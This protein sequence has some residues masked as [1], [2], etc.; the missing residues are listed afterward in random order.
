MKTTGKK[1]KGDR[2]LHNGSRASDIFFLHVLFCLYSLFSVCSKLG[3]QADSFSLPFFAWYG[4]AFLLLGIYAIGWQQILK[5]MSLLRA[6]SGKAVVV[7]WGVFWGA[8]L[9]QEAVTV[10]KVVGAFVTMAG[11]VLYYFFAEDHKEK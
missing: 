9:F 5:R 11:I 10:R 4:A 2:V 8:L 3:G 1:W 7:L 6:F